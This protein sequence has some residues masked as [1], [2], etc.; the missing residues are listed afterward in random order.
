MLKR[1]YRKYCLAPTPPTRK[2]F[3]KAKRS[4]RR[5]CL[6]GKRDS[7]RKF[8]EKTPDEK[9]MSMLFKL[10]QRRDKRA[11]NTLHK[12]DGSLTDPGVETIQ[13]LTDTHFPHATI[14]MS[15]FQHDSSHKISTNTIQDK[16]KDW[17]TGELV[18]KAFKRFKP[19]KA[20]GPDGLKPI[21]FKHL[22]QNAIDTLTLIYKACIALGHT[23][24]V[25][26]AT[27]VIFLP[28]PG[29]KTYDIGKSYRPISLSNYPLKALERLGVWKMDKDL[30]RAPIHNMQHGF[31]KG[32][33]TETAISNTVNCI[34]QHLFQDEHCLGLFLDI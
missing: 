19:N 2:A 1:K 34:E 15:P 10:A 22:P 13:V 3:V 4:Y 12:P 11:I 21:V 33:S 31:T 26:R 30:E 18:I 14:G 29:K 25:W 17:V 27:K 8:V 20:A 32:K 5:S 7:W 16:Y 23:P 28:K 24:K 6:K 9:S